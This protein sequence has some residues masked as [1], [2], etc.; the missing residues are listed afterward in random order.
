MLLCALLAGVGFVILFFAQHG[1]EQIGTR[2]RDAFAGAEREFARIHA[3]PLRAQGKAQHSAGGQ[4]QLNCLCTVFL[5]QTEMGQ[6]CMIFQGQI[7]RFADQR[8]I[9]GKGAGEGQHLLGGKLIQRA[10]E[11]GKHARLQIQ[12]G[13]LWAEALA[14]QA[15]HCFIL[16]QGAQQ[17]F[18]FLR[19]LLHGEG[20]GG[21]GAH[22]AIRVALQRH[23]GVLLQP[24]GKQAV[25]WRK[26]RVQLSL[27]IAVRRCNGIECAVQRRPGGLSCGEEHHGQCVGVARNG[28]YLFA[29][30][31]AGN[32]L[33]VAPPGQGEGGQLFI[34]AVEH[35]ARLR[36]AQRI[37]G[38]G[39]HIGGV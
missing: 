30:H 20:G 28:Q 1:G 9:G 6:R 5:F 29:Q 22:V 25:V 37:G 18:G 39:A 3:R 26:R 14:Q 11:Y 23:L 24:G 32:V 31:V 13:F 27:P 4:G 21:Y 19:G 10:D 17:L 38:F 16:I 33:P 15:Q 8:A 2:Q 35:Q 34:R 12:R 36:I 7:Q